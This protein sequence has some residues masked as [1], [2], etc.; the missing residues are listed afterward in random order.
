ML[1]DEAKTDQVHMASDAPDA[2]IRILT[3]ELIAAVTK[4]PPKAC[5][6]YHRYGDL[7]R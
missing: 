4:L 5:I 3:E 2:S 6:S 1:L 7:S